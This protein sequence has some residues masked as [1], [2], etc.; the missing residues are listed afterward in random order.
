VTDQIGRSR[1]IHGPND[2]S[3]VCWYTGPIG[4]DLIDVIFI[5]GFE[6]GVWFRTWNPCKLSASFSS[7]AA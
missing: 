7:A 3:P 1:A 4:F 6:Q 2:D 5:D